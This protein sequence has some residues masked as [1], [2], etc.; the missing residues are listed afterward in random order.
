VNTDNALD[1]CRRYQSAASRDADRAL[2]MFLT[3]KSERIKDENGTASTAPKSLKK[4]VVPNEPTP[5]RENR[6]P[7]PPAGPKMTRATAQTA[8]PIN[9]KRKDRR[10]NR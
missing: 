6:T 2:K 5:I 4:P 9:R 10:K 7:A 3:L 1:L 8:I